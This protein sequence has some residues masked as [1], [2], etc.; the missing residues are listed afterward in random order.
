[1]ENKNEH[2]TRIKVV[3]LVLTLRLLL[4]LEPSC[5]A[6]WIPLDTLCVL[7]H[8]FFAEL[9]FLHLPAEDSQTTASRLVD[10][11]VG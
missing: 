2:S 5:H 4:S 7:F 1:M 9:L 11:H 8:V 3:S 10:S 6:L